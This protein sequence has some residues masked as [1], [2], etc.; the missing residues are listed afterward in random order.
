MSRSRDYR[1]YRPGATWRTVEEHPRYLTILGKAATE[2]G[3]LVCEL[4]GHPR[5]VW[6]QEIT[7]AV[8]DQGVRI[9]YAECVVLGE[10]DER[11][12]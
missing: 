10:R 6:V 5:R 12:W 11:D 9:G 3:V 7:G 1:E 2:D 8:L 4:E